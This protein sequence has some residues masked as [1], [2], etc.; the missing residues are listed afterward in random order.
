MKIMKKTSLVLAL[1]LGAVSLSGCMEVP[2]TQGGVSVAQD[3]Y[4]RKVKFVN[5]TGVTVVGLYGSNVKSDSWGP[6]LLRGKHL[7]NGQSMVVDF[8]DKTGLCKFDLQLVYAD[9][10]VVQ[11]KAVN[12]CEVGT[13]EMGSN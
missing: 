3:Q 11:D 1:M 13:I 12:V 5:K 6:N 4:D 8:N 9:G 10:D 7:R 2:Q